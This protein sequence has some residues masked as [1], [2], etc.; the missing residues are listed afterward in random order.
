[1][2]DYDTRDFRSHRLADE[3][4]KI[5]K[6][7]KIAKRSGMQTDSPNRFAKKH[8]L[9]CGRPKCVICSNPRKLFKVKTIQERRFEQNYKDEE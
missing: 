3:Q 4:T 8:A 5:K 2:S 7:Y 9:D 6:Q 1:M